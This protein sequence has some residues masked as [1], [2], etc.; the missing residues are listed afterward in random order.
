MSTVFHVGRLVAKHKAMST[1]RLVSF[2][3]IPSRARRLSCSDSDPVRSSASR[4]LSSGQL[5]S[6]QGSFK[7]MCDSL[8]D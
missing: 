7:E 8:H 5:N 4:H 2:A 3:L 1:F 6:C